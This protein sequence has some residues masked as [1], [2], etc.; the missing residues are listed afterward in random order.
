MHQSFDERFHQKYQNFKLFSKCYEMS[1]Y[2]LIN[3][4]LIQQ[5]FIIIFNSYRNSNEDLSEKLSQY[6]KSEN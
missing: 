5:I 2:S 6:V 3:E 1:A 4:K